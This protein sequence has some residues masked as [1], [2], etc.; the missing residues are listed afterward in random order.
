MIDRHKTIVIFYGLFSHVYLN[1]VLVYN[2]TKVS[3]RGRYSDEDCLRGSTHHK[4]N[5]RHGLLGTGY[6]EG[7]VVDQ[8]Y[9]DGCLS[10]RPKDEISQL[11]EYS[12]YRRVLTEF[13][14]YRRVLTEY[15]EYR[16]VLTEFSEY[17]RVLTE[18]SENRRVL[19]EYSEYRRVH[20][21]L[22]FYT[23]K[24]LLNSSI[25]SP[26]VDLELSWL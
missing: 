11:N 23:T 21:K 7:R 5:E 24:S 22:L 10:P 6:S 1:V 12:E 15:S 13:S 19:T 18:Y 3:Q 2:A 8:W 9:H 26:T 25:P 17:R 16:R 20:K 4:S 14:E